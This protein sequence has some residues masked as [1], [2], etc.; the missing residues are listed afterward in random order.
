MCEQSEFN[1]LSGPKTLKGRVLLKDTINGSSYD[2][3]VKSIE[4]FL[5]DLKD[6]AIFLNSVRTDKDGYFSFGGID[7]AV[8]YKVYARIDTGAVKYYGELRYEI[9]KLEENKDRSLMLYPA[10]DIQNGMHVVVQD[11]GKA[12]MPGV[13]VWVYTNR[14]FY[15]AGTVE[16]KTLELT[17]N[18][19]GIANKMNLAPQTYYLRVKGRIGNIDISGTDS[20]TLTAAAIN[21]VVLKVTTT[22]PKRNG[23]EI[24]VE[25]IEG[26][27]I[28]GATVFAYRSPT[29]YDLDKNGT[30]S[31]FLMPSD[32]T[33]KAAA[34]DIDPALYYLR[35]VKIVGKDTLKGKDTISVSKTRIVDR[36]IILY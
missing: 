10:L 9:G 30:N 8:G 5:A 22:L 4:V 16:G 7:P 13:T 31:L 25:G 23:M 2:V 36:S 27:P 21:T 34:Y 19:S 35:A 18:A 33:G 24:L 20:T 14:S 6:T 29:I 12:R 15:N 26:A 17:T 3:P 1:D 28:D 11:A 32:K